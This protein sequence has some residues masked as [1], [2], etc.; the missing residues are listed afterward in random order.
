MFGEL[1]QRRHTQGKDVG[2]GTVGFKHHTGVHHRQVVLAKVREQ[3]HGVVGRGFN[4]RAAELV[5]VHKAVDEVDQDERALVAYAA[6]PAQ[7]LVAVNVVF[8]HA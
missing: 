3:R 4:V 2:V 7:A 5:E 6:A 8:V 1:L